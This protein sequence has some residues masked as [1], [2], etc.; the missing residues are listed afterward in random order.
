MQGLSCRAH[1]RSMR[2][3]FG[4]AVDVLRETDGGLD[5]CRPLPFFIVLALVWSREW[6]GARVAGQHPYFPHPVVYIT[7]H[8]FLYC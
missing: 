6:F 1:P 3:T 5:T 4:L 2:S 8:L 7:R